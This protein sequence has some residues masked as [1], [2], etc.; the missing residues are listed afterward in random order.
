MGNTSFHGNITKCF[1][2]PEFK[3]ETKSLF[4]ESFFFGEICCGRTYLSR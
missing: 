3:G 4:L 1:L 2:A